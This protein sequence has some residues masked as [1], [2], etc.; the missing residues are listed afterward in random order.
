MSPR[1]PPVHYNDDQT[2][3]ILAAVAEANPYAQPHN[4]K[5]AAWERAT[6]ILRESGAFTGTELTIKGVQDKVRALLKSVS[7]LELY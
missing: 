1:K 6:K 3:K 2:N 5:T 7:N 4:Q